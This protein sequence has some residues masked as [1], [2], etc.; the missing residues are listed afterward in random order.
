MRRSGFV[1]SAIAGAAVCILPARVRSQSGAAVQSLR[2]LLGNGAAQPIDAQSFMFNGRPYRGTFS[3]L[4]SGQVV[5]IVPLE[6]YLY[7]VVSKEM[8]RS[9]P[10]AALEAQAILARTYVLQ[11]SN[12]NR[13]YDVVPS[14]AD[15]VYGGIASETVQS[16]AAVTTTND[17]VLR[18]SGDFAQ[19]SYS[20]C[21]GGHTENIADAWGGKGFPYLAGVRCPYCTDSPDYRWSRELALNALSRAF[22][23][24]IDPLGAITSIEVAQS[25]GSGRARTIGISG[26]N[27][28]VRIP[29]NA[30]RSRLGARVV[31]SLL[32]REISLSAPSAEQAGQTVVIE[33]SGLGHGVGLCQWGARGMGLQNRSA[34][35]IIGFYFPNTEIGNA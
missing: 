27:G 13:D 34:K 35:D 26:T 11:R 12:P 10:R 9:W 22:A 4:G 23:A 29:G 5:S 8:P 2:V 14:E 15:Q 6:E 31:R 19:V 1:L 18:Y 30:L 32:I 17:R 25:D 33:G 28:S 16:V 20:S 21:C 24:E 3:M 7:S